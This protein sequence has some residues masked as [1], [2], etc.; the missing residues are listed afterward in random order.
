MEAMP[1][2]LW[3]RILSPLPWLPWAVA[4]LLLA[5]AVLWFTDKVIF[6]SFDIKPKLASGNVA[7]AI[8]VA[9]IVWA[10]V[11][12]FSRAAFGATPAYD[13]H[14]RRWGVH[15]FGQQVDWRQFKAQAMTESALRP[16]VC[17]AVGACGLMQ[18]MPGTARQLGVD[19]FRPREAIMGGIRYDRQL[20]NQWS[21]PRPPG[22]RLAFAW[23]SYNAGL[24][25][26]LKFQRRAAASGRCN[27]NRYGCVE[28]HVWRE[29]RDYA[30][31]IARWCVRFGGAG[32]WPLNTAPGG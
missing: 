12:I 32:C 14:F 23:I 17:S 30:R 24:G 21:A 22:E 4:V 13:G 29:P 8:V 7:V 3:D 27:A 26:A 25:N 1:V 20:W 6:R 15:Y 11:S 2:T 19:P 16:H 31:R 28:P 9:V 5:W 10:V 18:I